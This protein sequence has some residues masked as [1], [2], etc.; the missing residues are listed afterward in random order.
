MIT[1]ST[2][3]STPPVERVK[4]IAVGNAGINLMDRI[5]LETGGSVPC[6]A[7][8]SDAASLNACMA[9]EKILLGEKCLRGLGAG[10]DPDLGRRG[11]EESRE[12]LAELL[13]EAGGAVF[14]GG[15]GG[16][17]AGEVLV[18]MQNLA[19]GTN[20]PVFHIITLP[21]AFE[22]P[23]RQKLAAEQ[24][25]L[26]RQA[27]GLTAVFPN[28]RLGEIA[29]SSGPVGEAFAACDNLL[30]GVITS[31]LEILNGRGPWETS[32]GELCALLAES[33]PTQG[34]FYTTAVAKGGTRAHDVVPKL[35]K[36]PLAG[37]GLP[38]EEVRTVH[39]HLSSGTGLSLAEIRTTVDLLRRKFEEE[40]LFHIGVATD[41]REPQELA[42]TLFGTAHAPQSTPRTRSM[43]AP[44]SPAPAP[45]VETEQPAPAPVEPAISSTPPG[46]EAPDAPED[47]PKEEPPPQTAA[48]KPDSKPAREEGEMLPGLEGMETAPKPPVRPAKKTTP[49]PKQEVLPLDVASRGRF[50]RSEPTIEEGEDLDVPTFIRLKIRLK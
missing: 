25:L 3:Q 7:V 2:S 6:A 42:V 50:E 48:P 16:G 41:R 28:E 10:G 30:A 22:G 34:S 46:D 38:V 26:L 31:F 20:K 12:S 47:L 33:D 9:P 5:F 43:V 18:S 45:A 40:T 27:G 37:A 14:L 29:P 44:P 24:L 4:L 32:P 8:N 11:I 35:F 39:V 36:S 23:R 15:L 13:A 1:V 17:T 19:R 21:F 49:K